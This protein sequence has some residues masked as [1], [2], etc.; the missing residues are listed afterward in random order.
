MATTTSESLTRSRGGRR[1]GPGDMTG[2]LKDQAAVDQLQADRATQGDDLRTAAAEEEAQTNGVHDPQ[3]GKQIGTLRQGRDVEVIEA[4]DDDEDDDDVEDLDGPEEATDADESG[5]PPQIGRPSRRRR[6]S[7]G[8]PG[9]DTEPVFTGKEPLEMQV[10]PEAHPR[11]F[12][13]PE[14]EARPLKSTVRIAA[15]I[16]KMT[17]GMENGEPNNYSFREGFV[18]EV[19]TALADHL[20]ERHLI[21]QWIK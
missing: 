9:G 3:T 12:S 4:S 2:Q 10:A 19:P 18:Y 16:E 1:A 6:I 21:A 11:G 20:A 17:Y 14:Y 5:Q 13:R 8:F 15:D 7:S